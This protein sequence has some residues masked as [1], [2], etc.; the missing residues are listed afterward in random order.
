[1][2]RAIILMTLSLFFSIQCASNKSNKITERQ[3]LEQTYKVPVF[4]SADVGDFAYETLL[5]FLELKD[6]RQSGGEIKPEDIQN[7]MSDVGERLDS[8]KTKMTTDDVK[9]LTDWLSQLLI[10]IENEE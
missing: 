1:M 8:I 2:K 10:D 4:S 3:K 9:K 7:K 5:I 6:N